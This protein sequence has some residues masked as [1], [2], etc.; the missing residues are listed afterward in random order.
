MITEVTLVGGKGRAPEDKVRPENRPSLVALYLPQFHPIPENDEWWGAGFTEWTNVAKA[1]PL[2]CGHNQPNLPADLGFYDLRVPETREAQ[3]TMAR[4]YGIDAFCYYHYWFGNGQ[5]ILERPFEEVLEAGKPDFPFMLCWA[6]Q[7]WSGIWHGLENEV[8]A[9]QRY[10]GKSDHEAHFEKLLPAFNDP[11]YLRVDDKPVFMIYD[12][13]DLPQPKA[14]L[15]YWRVMAVEAGL[16]GLYLIAEHDDP[17]WDAHSFG[18]DAFVNQRQLPKRRKWIS[19]AN[20]V[21]KIHAKFLDLLQRPDIYDYKDYCE[22]FVPTHASGLAIPCVLPNWDNTPR[23]GSRGVV[24]KGSTPELFTKQLR[25][26]SDRANSR[27]APDNLIFI[28]SWNEW[29]EGNHLEPNK[30]FGFKYLEAVIS[31]FGK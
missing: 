28:K 20:P 27:S 17:Y 2:F 24:L 3:A 26:A 5:R 13:S 22:Y 9:E 4:K 14:T 15:D 19:W 31:T 12:I 30:Y 18:L 10:P 21:Q 23:S 16:E 11:R 25:Q 7:T 29:A 6:N 1:Q 8:L